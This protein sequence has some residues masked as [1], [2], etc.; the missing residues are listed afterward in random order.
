MRFFAGLL[1]YVVGVSVL[2]SIG[3][4]GFMAVQSPTDRTR[5]P[6]TASTT[7]NN[8]RVVSPAKS[9]MTAQKKT[10]PERKNKVARTVHKRMHSLPA[11]VGGGDAYGY[12][13]APR[14]RI[15]PNM[16]FIFGR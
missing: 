8:E 3:I 7:S 9:E 12:A 15:D 13:E 2:I 6:P 1:A 16:F 14:Y 11:T 4:V 5:A 10:P